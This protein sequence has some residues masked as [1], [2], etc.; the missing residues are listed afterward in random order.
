MESRS[1]RLMMIDQVSS[2]IVNKRSARSGLLK[3]EDSGRVKTGL[4]NP[5]AI[6]IPISC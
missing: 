6:I 3:A 2:S 1:G 5:V 4:K